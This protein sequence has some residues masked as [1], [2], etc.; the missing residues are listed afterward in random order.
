MSPSPALVVA[1]ELAHAVRDLIELTSD[2]SLTIETKFGAGPQAAARKLILTLEDKSAAL[3][4]LESEEQTG[5]LAGGRAGIAVKAAIDA[6]ADE[7]AAR[8]TDQRAPLDDLMTAAGAAAWRSCLGY[9]A[10]DARTAPAQVILDGAIGAL[11]SMIADLP[12]ALH[13]P[14]IHQVVK[15][16]PRQVGETILAR[17]EVGPAPSI[18]RDPR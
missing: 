8:R 11:A 1:Y 4:K 12:P 18:I 14:S 5:E 7:I 15:E 6:I 16:L 2:G 10:G 3:L 9:A 13:V 17:A